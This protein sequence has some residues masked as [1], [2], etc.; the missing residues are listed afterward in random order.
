LEDVSGN[1]KYRFY[2]SNDPSGNDEVRKDATTLEND[3]KSFVFDQQWTKVFLYGKEVD[4][5]HV[6][7]KQKLFALNFSATQELDKI[8]QEEKAKVESLEK[9][10]A[11]LSSKNALLESKVTTLENKTTTLETQLADVL[12]RLSAL[13]NSN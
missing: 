11:E 4:D 12:A 5:F 7:D 10:N 9:E 13:E 8:Q 6:L 2:M 3:P 1:T